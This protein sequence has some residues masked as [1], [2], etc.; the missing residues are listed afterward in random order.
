MNMHLSNEYKPH[1]SEVMYNRGSSQNTAN[2]QGLHN[3]TPANMSYA[4]SNHLGQVLTGEIIQVTPN[5]VQLLL[6]DQS[7]ISARIEGNVNLSLHSTM[8]FEV[9]N[10]QGHNL[11]LRPLY[12]NTANNQTLLKALDAA[13]IPKNEK[14]IELVSKQMESNQPIDKN[15]L[16]RIYHDISE[17]PQAK[18]S[19]IVALRE[20][21]LPVNENNL[22][23]F[24]ACMNLKETFSNSLAQLEQQIMAVVNELSASGQPERVTSFLQELAKAFEGLTAQS[25]QQGQQT[26]NVFIHNGAPDS[27]VMPEG[28]PSQS[29]VIA[30][31]QPPH[32]VVIVEGQPSQ[33]IDTLQGQPSQSIVSSEGQPSQSIDTPQGQLSQSSVV[34]QDQGLES[35]GT[36]KEQ[37]E[38]ERRVKQLFEKNLVWDTGEMADESKDVLKSY[39][40]QL[41]NKVMSTTEKL[42]QIDVSKFPE[43]EQLQKSASQTH[44]QVRF[45]ND[46]NQSIMYL[47]IPLKASETLKDGHLHV[48][49]RNK[50]LS[51]S[52]DEVTALIHLDMEHLGPVSVYVSLRDNHIGTKFYLQDEETIDLIG[53]HIDMLSKRIKDRGYDFHAEMTQ[54]KNDY[55]PKKVLKNE[56]GFTD[57]GMKDSCIGQYSFDVRA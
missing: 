43:A 54:V 26:N 45:L 36:V 52:Q 14:T 20:L 28:Q 51:S 34:P 33:S 48:Y 18:V 5:T 44:N 42:A 30:K 1:D 19:D 10:T 16:Q 41:Y 7:V 15:T 6:Q 9:S 49:A 46:L 23:Q 37:E 57:E 50:K 47:Q 35:V 22:T 27:V 56:M 40:K 4:G 11:L 55:D 2:T 24:N 53:Q 29:V 17:Y 31:G 13:G 25:G 3:I 21:G 8:S 39:V 12:L 38:I 32:N